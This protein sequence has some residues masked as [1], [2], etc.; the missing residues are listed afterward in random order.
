MILGALLLQKAAGAKK[1]IFAMEDNKPEALEALEKSSLKDKGFE[2]MVLPTQYPQGGEK[3]LIKVVL[4]REVPSGGLPMDVNALVQNV[5]TAFAVYEAVYFEKPLIER[6]VSVTGY[7]LK[8]PGNYKVKLG[9]KL[10]D[11]LRQAGRE[12][13]KQSFVIMGGPMMGLPVL[14]METPVIKSTSGILVI[15]DMV[16][17][18]EFPCIRCGR[19][20]KHCPIG[21]STTE[22][23]S[24]YNTNAVERMKKLNALDCIECGCCAYMCPAGIPLVQ[25]LKLSKAEIRKNERKTDKK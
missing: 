8:K 14:D 20:I 9:T 18:K 3:Q 6:I 7:G 25:Y 4:D 24:A 15:D 16:V 13:G 21:L 22:I 11:I 12:E 17:K 2:F 5:A 23:A 19:C 1:V 10:A